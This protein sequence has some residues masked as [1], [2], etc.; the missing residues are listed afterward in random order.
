MF[1]RHFSYTLAHLRRYSAPL[2]FLAVL[3]AFTAIA[4]SPASTMNPEMK[5]INVPA[6]V[7]ELGFS[8]L[9]PADFNAVEIKEAKPDFN[10]PTAFVGLEMSAASY[11]VVVFSVVARPA[12]DDGT[13]ED[14]VDYLALQTQL[15]VL[16]KKPI[17]LNGVPA[18]LVE[19][20][21][22]SDLGRMRMRS[23]LFEDGTRFV[24]VSVV[25]PDSIWPSVE[26]TLQRMLFSFRL[27]NPRGTQVP[28]TRA[29]AG[30]TVAAR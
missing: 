27:A 3:S 5:L 11:G 13:I 15:A 19:T 22:N 12:F 25:A 21:Q 7:A 23:A 1:R 8:Y 10:Q 9:R 2:A 29:A 30:A 28:L 26:E 18:L 17:D 24:N 20:L 16:S 14:W 6:R 4:K